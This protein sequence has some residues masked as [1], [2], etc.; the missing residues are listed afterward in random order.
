MAKRTVKSLISRRKLLVGTSAFAVLAPFARSFV[1]MAKAESNAP[2]RL[3]IFYT[4][5]G[6]VA[7]KFWPT[8][9]GTSFS[10]K[11]T[12]LAPLEP[13]KQDLILLKDVV[14]GGTGDH[15]TG[16]YFCTSGFPAEGHIS[17]DQKIG[18]DL[19]SAPLVLAG[20]YWSNRRGHMSFA[21]DGSFVSPLESPKA[22]YES[23]FGPIKPNSTP[24]P[25]PP[26]STPT[27]APANARDNEL[28]NR[29]LD[30]AIADIERVK[31]RLPERELVKMEEHL[32]A[33]LTLQKRYEGEAPVGGGPAPVAC[34][35]DGSQ[36]DI[37]Y[38]FQKRVRSHS[39]LI[40][41][42]FACDA[43]RIVSFQTA[44]GGHDGLGL[45][46]FGL[47]GPGGDMHQDV[48]HFY[49]DDAAKKQAM[50]DVDAWHA[51]RFA[52]L[53][54][55]LKNTPEGDGSVFDNTIV[56]WTNECSTP[57]HGHAGIPV[58]VASGLDKLRTGQV[59]TGVGRENYLKLLITLAQLMGDPIET[60]GESGGSGTYA[61]ILV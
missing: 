30:A 11:D 20:K 3:V 40:A 1:R 8:G 59:R 9:T 21:T 2:T 13:H 25:T 55:M 32:D 23:V 10:M 51:A 34:D 61:D 26:S 44:P 27:P 18:Q 4:P 16:Q 43:R 46:S 14:F 38:D 45:G 15:K 57:N 54:G 29:I 53:I 58:L 48:A 47:T 56:L 28:E 60:F 17:I 33:V 7:E 31:K 52:D 37:S 5:N 24:S 22:A 41:T 19:N 39:E 36:F 50:I 49:L 35:N 42:V 12:S 6:C